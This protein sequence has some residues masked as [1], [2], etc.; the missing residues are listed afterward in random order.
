MILLAESI[1]KP[2]ID[3]LRGQDFDVRYVTEITPSINDEE[4]SWRITRIK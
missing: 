2:V 4:D 3:W 1:G